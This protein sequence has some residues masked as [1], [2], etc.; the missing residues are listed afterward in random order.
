V[1]DGAN[2]TLTPGRLQGDLDAGHFNLDQSGKRWQRVFEV[3]K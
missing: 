1:A 3:F 2:E